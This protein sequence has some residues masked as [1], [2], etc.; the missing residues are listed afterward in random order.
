[1]APWSDYLMLVL[2][3]CL[4]VGILVVF[5][6]TFRHL[7]ASSSRPDPRFV[8]IMLYV[9]MACVAF[10]SWILWKL[11]IF[12]Y[13]PVSLFGERNLFML[14]IVLGLMTAAALNGFLSRRLPVSKK[15][16]AYLFGFGTLVFATVVGGATLLLN[17]LLDRS[18]PTVM[19][20]AV[21]RVYKEKANHMSR[22]Y[23]WSNTV[24][25]AEIDDLCAGEVE[26]CR[27]AIDEALYLQIQSEV[28]K[29][30]IL[31]SL[32]PGFFGVEWVLSAE[33]PALH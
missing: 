13:P 21:L 25:Y 31:L 14:W 20:K 30:Q 16:K 22:Q 8:P 9:L 11:A 24:Y 4:G 10:G 2:V 3:L 1:M 12:A 7:F 5:R 28:G 27:I 29:K 15:N 6:V 26:D 33:L 19:P 32:K 18:H 17:G 23:R